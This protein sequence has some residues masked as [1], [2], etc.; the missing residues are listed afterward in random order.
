M[1]PTA[2]VYF[3]DAG[4]KRVSGAVNTL[5]SPDHTAGDGTATGSG[6]SSSKP[7]PPRLHGRPGN[8]YQ[9]GSNWQQL[10]HPVYV[11]AKQE[12]IA[13]FPCPHVLKHGLYWVGWFVIAE[14]EILRPTLLP[15]PP[16]E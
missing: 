14:I 1:A 3:V 16:P 2:L 13:V 10:H 8:V 4:G 6:S 5:L 9:C 15:F 11:A 12:A 7:R